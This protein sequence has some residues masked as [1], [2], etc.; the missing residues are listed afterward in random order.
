MLICGTA[1][2][3]E[4]PLP[5]PRHRLI[6]ENLVIIRYNSFDG[7]ER[8]SLHY[9][10]RLYNKNGPAWNDAHFGLGFQPIT[11]FTQTRLGPTLTLKPIAFLTFVA[12]YYYNIWYGSFGN[13]R[14][15]DTPDADYFMPD[16]FGT[17]TDAYASSGHE[18]ELGARISFAVGPFVFSNLS[19]FY[20]TSMALK[21]GDRWYFQ[22]RVDLL[23]Q[24]KGW[25]LADDADVGFI[26]PFGLNVLAR[27]SI[28][29]AFYTDVDTATKRLNT[30]SLLFG[31]M[32]T[33]QFFDRAQASYNKPTLI[34]YTAWWLRNRYRSGTEVGGGVP[35]VLLA[36]KFEGDIWWR[37]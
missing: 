31:P 32:L 29:H 10:L 33:Y 34:L 19:S 20:W 1:R 6:Y 37:D 27:T 3:A 35:F 25:Y 17:S 11:N 16:D 5:P 24:N 12:G 28:F 36:F 14:S 13:L 2:A 18:L 26:T 8:P 9:R 23:V 15:Y 21:S 4:D 22:P 7:E 30:P